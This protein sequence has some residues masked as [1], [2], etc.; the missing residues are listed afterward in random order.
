MMMVMLT[1]TW[2]DNIGNDNCGDDGGV[3]KWY[4]MIIDNHNYDGDVDRC[5][6]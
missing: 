5:M 2:S 6:M 1:N 4:R 3:D